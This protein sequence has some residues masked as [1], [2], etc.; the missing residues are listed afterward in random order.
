GVSESRRRCSLWSTSDLAN[1]SRIA[2]G[3][4]VVHGRGVVT[5]IRHPQFVV[6]EI[7]KDAARIGK[8]RM[9]S[10]QNSNRSHIAVRVGAED[11]HGLTGIVG[12]VQ[13]TSLFIDKE[14]FGPV[15]LRFGTTNDANRRS[16]ASGLLVINRDGCRQVS[17]RAGKHLTGIEWP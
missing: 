2:G 6:L 4:T 3:G 17:P 5:K 7:D 11:Q 1:R 9:R 10:L 14:S 8:Q 13:F 15:Q 12:D 16:I